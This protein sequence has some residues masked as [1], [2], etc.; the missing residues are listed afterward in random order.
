[1][2]GPYHWCFQHG[3]AILVSQLISQDGIFVVLKLE[4]PSIEF[5]FVALVKLYTLVKTFTH[6]FNAVSYLEGNPVGAA[7]LPISPNRTVGLHY[8]ESI[9]SPMAVSGITTNISLV[10]KIADILVVGQ[11]LDS[12]GTGV[13]TSRDWL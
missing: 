13:E 4:A 12:A 8:S 7:E 2:K 11:D 3:P 10:D 9:W 5:L 6:I 1:M